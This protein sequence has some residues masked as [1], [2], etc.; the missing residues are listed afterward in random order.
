MTRDLFGLLFGDKGDS[1]HHLFQEL[2]DRGLKRITPIRKNMKN[3]LMNL[4]E[5]LLL[6]KRSMIEAVDD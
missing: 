6:R 2:Y 4:E 5:Q 3:R 1:S